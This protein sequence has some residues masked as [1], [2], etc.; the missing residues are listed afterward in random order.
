MRKE[1]AVLKIKCIRVGLVVVLLGL[2]GCGGGGSALNE[3]VPETVTSSLDLPSTPDLSGLVVTPMHAQVFPLGVNP[4]AQG[5]ALVYGPAQIRQAYQLPDLP[6]SWSGLSADQRA[7]YGAGQTVYVIGAYHNPNAWAELEAFRQQFNLPGC[8]VVSLAPTQSLPLL[9]ASTN[10]CEF[11]VVYASASGMTD[12]QPDYN[13]GWAQE[14]ALDVQWVHA[15]AP[16][17][18]IVLIEA[19]NASTPRILDAINLANAMG[20]G[21][22]SMSFGADE[23]AY[24]SAL[25]SAFSAANMTY[26]AATGDS[27]AGKAQWPSVSKN[28]LAVGGT[29]LASF[30]SSGTRTETV[31]Q[32][33]PASGGSTGGGISQYV[34][35]PDYQ[36]GVMVVQ[37]ANA[38]SKKRKV[39]D[40]AF[41]AD[42][43]TGQYVAIMAQG[44]NSASWYSM[45]G[46]SLSTPQWAG[47]VAVANAM[48]ANQQGPLGLVQNLIYPSSKT[49]ATYASVFNDIS[50]GRSGGFSAATGYDI[51]TGLGSPNVTAFLNLATGQ[52]VGGGGNGNGSGTPPPSPGGTPPTVSDLTVKGVAGA[53]LSFSLSYTA[54]NAVTWSATGAPSGLNIDPSTGIVSWPSPVAGTFALKV[55]ATDQVTGLSNAPAT[56]TIEVRT[57]SAAEA[58]SIVHDI[59]IEGRTGQALSW[60]LH[61]IHMNPVVFS[62]SGTVP[63][64]LNLSPDGLLTWDSPVAGL[65]QATVVVQDTV[66]KL[67]DS[68]TLTLRIDQTQATAPTPSGPQISATPINGTAGRPLMAFI[69]I[70]DPGA[71]SVRVS[72][73]GAPSGM[74]FGLSGLG[75]MVR[76]NR[77]VKGTYNL[78]IQARDDNKLSAQTTVVVTIQ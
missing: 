66:T 71:N 6:N 24:V 23:G 12:K 57:S 41:N 9:S 55:I 34:S 47:I 30:T 7:I 63:A 48:R 51:P 61:A 33:S 37:E 29:S 36:S 72:I 50:V 31:W 16:L 27:G 17:A 2:S 25:D 32:P 21:V 43:K 49:A 11:S 22:V 75:L 78:V 73:K 10:G 54:P 53:P 3:V 67:T 4:Q 70:T 1:L 59:V 46:T 76:W 28:V 62:F 13:S 69:G 77:P 8:K 74:N 68:S 45:G 58:P 26:L 56:A 64:G 5:G 15:M 52:S 20:S 42:P 19:A 35:E 14:M 40:V 18:R 39:A 38:S 65:T 44:A 60:A